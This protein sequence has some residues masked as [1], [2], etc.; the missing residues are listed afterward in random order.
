MGDTFRDPFEQQIELTA[1]QQACVDYAGERTLMVKGCAGSGKSIVL[2]AA[3]KRYQ[4]AYQNADS[5]KVAIFTFQNTLVST[6]RETLGCN[7]EKPR[8]VFVSTCNSFLNEIYQALVAIGAAPKVSFNLYGKKREGIIEGVLREHQEKYGRHRFQEMSAGFWSEEFDWMK[9]MNLWLG[10]QDAYLNTPRTGRSGKVRMS[11]EDRVA[12]FQLFELY[13]QQ[14]EKKHLGDWADQALYIIRHQKQI[15]EKYQY[16]HVLIDEAQDLSLTQMMA[17]R[18]VAQRDMLIAMDA[19][20]RIH[21][22]YWTPKLLGISA[23]TKKLTKAMRTTKQIDELAESIRRH[24]DQSLEEDDRSIRVIP[25]REGPIPELVHLET[26]AEEKKYVVRQVRDYLNQNPALTIGMI[27]AKNSQI[28]KLAGWFAEEGIHSEIISKDTT[29]S[30]KKPGLK[31]VSAFSAKGLE[32]HV[33]IIP[34]FAKGYFP[35]DYTSDDPEEQRAFLTQMRNLIYVSM[36]RAKN[37]LILTYWGQGGSPFIGEMDKDAYVV[38][39]E[40]IDGSYADLPQ[41]APTK[42]STQ[43]EVK[44]PPAADPKPEEASAS[45]LVQFLTKAGISYEDKREKG[46]ALWIFGDKKVLSAVIKSTRTLY[47]A[48]WIYSDK[49]NGYFTKCAK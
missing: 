32:F 34:M 11:S 30:M 5:P 36:T 18:C 9:D 28:D 12:A 22:K 47:G 45:A 14:L 37:K 33:V 20:Q 42:S 7:D 38:K 1:E 41:F 8:A 29:F 26:P 2:M 35:Y 27:A 43:S 15:P 3:A 49:K 25:E 16:R 39:G 24:N 23:T 48:M 10:D 4:E 40:P 6:I 21:K 13:C 46:G 44:L 17:L 19:N 31:I